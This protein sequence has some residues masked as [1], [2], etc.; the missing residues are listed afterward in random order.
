MKGPH[1]PSVDES[2]D[3]LRRAGWSVG[4]TAFGSEHAQV[5]LVTGNYGENV[6]HAR[7]GTQGEAWWNACVQARALGMLAPPR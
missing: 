7:G 5:W 6:F 2:L 3:R 1:Y 4:D